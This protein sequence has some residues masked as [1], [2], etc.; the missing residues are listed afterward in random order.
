MR[1]LTG[2][3]DDDHTQYLLASGSRALAGAWNM[4]SKA[5]TNVNIDSG[6]IDNAV[7]H[8]EWD[9]A[10]SHISSNGSSHSYINQNVTSGSSP[11]FDGANFTGIDHG[12]LDGLSD[13]D[14]TQYLLAS[15]SRALAGAW[16]MNS[17]ALT[18]VNIDSGTIDNAVTHTEWDAAYSHISS[19]GSSHSYID[20]DVTS[21]SKPTFNGGNFTGI[22]H[23]ALTGLGDDDHT[24]YV[25]RQPTADTV[26]NN[27][28]GDFNFRVEGDTDPFLFVVDAG[29]DAVSIGP[30]YSYTDKFNVDGDILAT[31]GVHIGNSSDLYLIDD[32]S[33]GSSHSNLYIG[34]CIISLDCSSDERVKNIIKESPKILPNLLNWRVVEYTFKKEIFEDDDGTIHTGLIAQDIEKGAQ[35]AVMERSDGWKSI[36]SNKLIP[37]LVKAIQEQQDI[38]SNQQEQINDLVKRIEKLEAAK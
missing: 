5:L 34:N 11:T 22:N 9:A 28:G 17:K 18:N 19:N 2:L 20:Q 8:T 32:S 23:G 10:Y 1:A 33:H 4:N 36:Q 37:Y 12:D 15:G 35:N 27:S 29:E 6:T 38:I 25:L 31:G 7:T 14:H 21:G 16:N 26:I 13:D 3:G 24:Q 30:A